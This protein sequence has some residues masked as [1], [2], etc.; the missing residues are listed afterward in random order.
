M[1]SLSD[2][3]KRAGVSIATASLVLRGMKRFTPEIERRVR[4]A[5]REL[6]YRPNRAARALRTGESRTLGVLA[7]D[8]ANPFF[9]GLMKRLEAKARELGYAIVLMDANESVDEEREAIAALDAYGVDGVVWIP[10]AD[11]A[12]QRPNAPVVVV[13]RRID[14]YDS[15]QSDHAMG[16]RLLG[17]HALEL[18]HRRIGLVSGP[19]HLSSAQL[20]RSGLL[21][22]C[23]AGLEVGWETFEPFGTELGPGTLARLAERSVSLVVCGNDLQAIAVARALR[24]MD[25]RV[26]EDVAVA[27]Y[28]DIVFA[29]LHEPPLT[30][31]RQP[32]EAIASEAL[33]LLMA[34]LHDPSLAVRSVALAVELK[35]RGSVAPLVTAGPDGEDTATQ[36]PTVEAA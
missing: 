24:D 23:E 9:P 27:G 18:G 12:L 1:T 22:Q 16:G 6:D 13:D 32:V 14:G 25:L 4:T 29:S 17:Q 15:V 21:A 3:A 35:R 26:P 2:V 34:R 5:A 7:P 19:Q 36:G 33:R 11:Q 8:I 28:D 31:I 10:V 20:R 30:T